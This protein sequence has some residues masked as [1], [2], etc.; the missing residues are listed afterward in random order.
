MI[1]A[2]QQLSPLPAACAVLA[3]SVMMLL[4]CVSLAQ[5]GDPSR[6]VSPRTPSAAR[7]L[8]TLRTK[9]F[10]P[11]DFDQEVFD[12]LWKIWPEPVRSE[13][14]S[15]DSEQR[16][17]LTFE[18]YGLVEDPARGDSGP[19]MGYV[20]SGDGTWVMNCLAC[21]GG[22]VAGNAMPGLPNSHYA[23]QTLT[24]DVARTKLLQRK[25]LSH[26]ESA[27][28]TLPLSQT[29][30]TTNSVIF[31]VVLGALRDPDMNADT[32]RPVPKLQHHDLDAPP[33][34]NVKY[35]QSLYA[36]G[37][38]PKNHRVLMQF[39][40]L[41]ENDAA[42]MR[43][44]ENDFR[45]IQ[46]WIESVEAPAWPWSIDEG[47]ASRGRIVFERN[48]SGC[49]GTYGDSPRYT[50][51]VIPIEE[52]G[53]DSLR[54]TALNAT[55]RQWLK[56]SWMSYYG[57]DYVDTDPQG[58]VAPP[59]HGIWASAPYLHNGSVP[60]LWHVL[61]PTERPSVWR[62]DRDGYD[63]SRVGINVEEF[64]AM[65]GELMPMSERRAFFDTSIPG[66]SSDGHAFPEKLTED[67]RRQVLEYLK[68]L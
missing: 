27:A 8:E 22:T 58:Y 49:H 3:R 66:K 48:C 23:L 1:D 46:A 33:F 68:T 44:W 13:A 34:W 47:Q 61:H 19:A 53:T 5:A 12:A 14:E 67:E 6:L 4:V 50:Q 56:E 16:R 11:P 15:A 63:R 28:V 52:V 21:H 62:R 59:L 41:P 38:A 42:V 40:M 29:N 64:Q 24:E 60:T 57:R 30:G 37:F 26:L 39:M 9:A 10:L 20:D 65:P 51:R 18:Y 7:G 25:P 43:G 45:D 17:R 54:L 2:F 55:H 35:K 31:G 32:T 36:D